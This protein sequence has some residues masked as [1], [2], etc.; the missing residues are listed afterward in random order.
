MDNNYHTFGYSKISQLY[1]DVKNHSN[2]TLSEKEFFINII[3][4][5]K[6]WHSYQI[7]Y[8]PTQFIKEYNYPRK[9]YYRSLNK[10]IEMKVLRKEKVCGRDEEMINKRSGYNKLVKN[11]SY[12]LVLNDIE[13]W[14]LPLIVARKLNNK[15]ISDGIMDKKW[16]ILGEEKEYQF[17][18]EKRKRNFNKELIKKYKIENNIIDSKER[19]IKRTQEDIIKLKSYKKL[20][21]M[22]LM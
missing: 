9:S 16:M 11:I 20:K 8:M 1:M 2:F 6:K 17:T 12:K 15:Y 13:D 22:R 18:V 10:M 4:H 3:F 19:D 14:V 7:S 5:F 21:N